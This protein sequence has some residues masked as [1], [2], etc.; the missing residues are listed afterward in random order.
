M[1]VLGEV[2]AGL[3]EGLWRLA[4]VGLLIGELS[5]WGAGKMKV[6]GAR[7]VLGE[8]WAGAGPSTDTVEMLEGKAGLEEGRVRKLNG[9]SKGREVQSE[10]GLG[11]GRRE[12]EAGL[13]EWRGG[14]EAGLGEGSGEREAGLGGNGG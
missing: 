14:A 10:A 5:L 13:V 2:P 12:G 1:L 6:A 11:E 7:G 8:G 3:P 4:K 9:W